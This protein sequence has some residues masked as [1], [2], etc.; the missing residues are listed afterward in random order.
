M[1][2][3]H[4][5]WLN[6]LFA[7]PV[8][9]V[10]FLV[11]AKRRRTALAEF[12]GEKLSASLAPGRSWRKGLAKAALRTAGYALIVAALAGPQFGSHLVKIEREGIDLVIALDTSLS[13]LAEDMKPNRLERA[14]QEIVDLIE[15]LK[16]DRVGI[17]VFAGDAF[18]LCP[19]T[20]DYDAALMLVQTADVAMV[21][22][23]GTA[24]GRAIEKS[25]ELFPQSSKADRAVILVTD[26]EGHEGD[27]VDEAERASKLGVRIYTIGIGNPKGELIPLRGTGGSVDGYKKDETGETILSR[28]DETTLRKI[29][30]AAN[31]Q[32]LPATREGIELKV[33]YREISGLERAAIKGEFLEK[34][35]DKFAW[36]LGAGFVAL[37]I[38]L[39]TISG[40]RMKKRDGRRILHTGAAA[41]VAALVLAALAPAPAAA[42]KIDK[43]R[44][45]SGNQYYKAGE[46]QKSLVLYQEALGDST[47]PAEN[48]EGVLYN[49]GNA[50]HMLGRYPEALEKY[51]ESVSDD[52]AQTGRML[53]NRA[54]TL[55]KM[56]KLPE[57]VESY[58]QSLAYLPDDED[59]RHN[60]ELALRALE[61]QKQ[62][63][64]NQQQDQ[65]NDQ[66]K[67]RQQGDERQKD[68]Q[69]KDDKGENQQDQPPDSTQI[70][71]QPSPQDSSA[72]RPELPD[73]A[74]TIELSREDAL[75][76]LKLLEEQEKE[77]QKEKRKA[78]FIRASRSGKD[79]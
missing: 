16:G 70:Q 25:V 76:L 42:K 59:A 75:R 72:A 38:D 40:G 56:G 51:H 78:A 64:Q 34:K 63:E 73:S 27:P 21:S 6:A 46:Y 35:K 15:G 77:L 39:A 14:K 71:P 18:A 36:F 52:T 44:V 3:A 28:L 47:R 53:Y 32:Y 69:R 4:P 62:Q 58:L 24:L 55:A 20:V 23:P 1:S 50:L 30:S 11:G 45:K 29:A 68:Q 13:M 61:E 33:L 5:E 22:E 66:Q 48:A 49:E 74:Q 57:A 19:L 7:V 31:G 67:D 79:W 65:K 8:L 54:N 9:A 2:F 12:T 17:V 26:G 43:G 37:L 10:L 60:L 41:V